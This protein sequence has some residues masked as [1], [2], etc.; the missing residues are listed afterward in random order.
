MPSAQPLCASAVAPAEAAWRLTLHASR[1]RTR[2][3]QEL[4]RPAARALP[5]QP[6]CAARALRRRRAGRHS[7]SYSPRGV[8]ATVARDAETRAGRPHRRRRDR[9]QPH[10]HPGRAQAIAPQGD[11][12]AHGVS[13]PTPPPPR[14]AILPPPALSL[15][16]P[17][18]PVAHSPA[19]ACRLT[20]RLCAGR[21]Y[22]SARCSSST[23][24][25]PTCVL[26]R[27]T[28]SPAS[29]A[30][31]PIGGAG[32]AFLPAAPLL[33]RRPGVS[34]RPNPMPS[35]ASTTSRC[36]LT[37]AAFQQGLREYA[38]VAQAAAAAAAAA[39]SE[40][41]GAALRKS[42][43]K[44]GPGRGPRHR[45]FSPRMMCGGGEGGEGG[46]GGGG[47]GGGEGGEGAWHV[48]HGLQRCVDGI[49]ARA[50]R[51]S[52]LQALLAQLALR[53]GDS[54]QDMFTPA[55]QLL[56]SGAASLVKSYGGSFVRE[57]ASAPLPQAST[58]QCLLFTDC[59]LCIERRIDNPSGKWQVVFRLAL[60]EVS[61]LAITLPPCT[62]RGELPCYH[63]SRLAPAAVQDRIP[64]SPSPRYLARH[65]SLCTTL[66]SGPHPHIGAVQRGRGR[67]GRHGCDAHELAAAAAACVTAGG[68]RAVLPTTGGRHRRTG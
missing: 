48:M 27:A 66:G 25:S 62:V 28:A 33:P 10:R 47:G 58:Q 55:R 1:R 19:L 7:L 4:V 49:F 5:R 38:Q 34:R 17:L 21:G 20:S 40:P 29:T 39:E 15:S 2:W 68:G 46:E 51:A 18:G 16:L 31:R 12:E 41:C 6:A 30:S 42:R 32:G 64:S 43:A 45:V 8:G 52:K 14:T 13:P 57:T 3:H 36:G 50:Q 44:G 35:H 9:L 24:T 67:C 65:P 56:H 11:P 54:L 53:A 26:P 23:T 59:L 22:R 61:Y 37:D 60:S 63:P